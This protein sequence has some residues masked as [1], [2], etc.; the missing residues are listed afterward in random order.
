MS[1]TAQRELV[2]AW[3]GLGP[4]GGRVT[5]TSVAMSGR[6]SGRLGPGRTFELTATWTG[7]PM[8]GDTSSPAGDVAFRQDSHWTPD[9]ELAMAA[10][11]CARDELRVPVV[12]DLAAI[13]RE[14]ARR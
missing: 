8:A 12:P 7:P 2:R 14:L 1:A 4:W 6:L 9:F 5:V 13:A 3:E 10:A 11:E